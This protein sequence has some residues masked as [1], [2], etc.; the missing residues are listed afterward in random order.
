[1]PVHD[2]APFLS[3]SIRS[4][5][6]Q[7]FRDLELVILDD[8]STDESPAI[9]REWAERDDRIR[10][11]RSPARLGPAG[12]S[13]GVVA[14]ARAPVCAPLDAADVPHPDRPRRQWAV[15]AADPGI[16]LVGCLWRGIDAGGRMVRPRD[17]WQLLRPSPSAPFAHGSIMFRREAFEAVGGYRDEWGFAASQELYGR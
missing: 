12:S 10:L 9:L 1:M 17:R 11:L 3:A 6:D 15:L 13:N 14:A 5:L 8:A 2:A 7:P 16:V 4:I